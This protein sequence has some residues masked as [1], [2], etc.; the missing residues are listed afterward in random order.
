MF[1]DLLKR[2]KFT[3][4]E[5]ILHLK[6]MLNGPI[7]QKF[8]LFTISTGPT[9]RFEYFL[10]VGGSLRS[11]VAPDPG[12]R[13]PQTRAD[14][15][16][17]EDLNISQIRFE[18]GRVLSHDS[19]RNLRPPQYMVPLGEVYRAGRIYGE[20]QEVILTNFFVM[21]DVITPK[22]SLWIL[23]RYEK[24][25]ERVNRG[26]RWERVKFKKDRDC[27]FPGL[28]SFDTVVSLTTSRNGPV[29]LHSREMVAMNAFKA[30][31]PQNW[32]PV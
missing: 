5:T 18:E 20:P 3:S 32:V 19:Y 9:T 27:V 26:V 31:L 1:L 29:L 10:K 30:A 15:V 21:M 23:Y 12:L 22:K 25:V 7:A 6:T 16:T 17:T 2:L 14:Q 28:K 4:D 13:P 11:A 8:P 24:R